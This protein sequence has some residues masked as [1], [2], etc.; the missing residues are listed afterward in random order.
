MLAA[1]MGMDLA[2]LASVYASTKEFSIKL[3]C[4]CC[5]AWQVESITRLVFIKFWA[6][7]GADGD[8]VAGPPHDARALRTFPLPREVEVLLE[9]SDVNR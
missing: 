2:V 5:M 8:G 7:N 4:A 6:E 9:S 1:L 3:G